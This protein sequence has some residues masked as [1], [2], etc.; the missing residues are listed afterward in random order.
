M[1]PILEPEILNDGD[2]SI[3]K[4]LETHEEVLSTLFRILK[5]NH[6]FLEGIILKLAMVLP[7]T[8]SSTNYPPEVKFIFDTIKS[9]LNIRK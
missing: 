1:V 5:K 7:G 3:E 2:H 8:Q 4:S 6:V 9:F